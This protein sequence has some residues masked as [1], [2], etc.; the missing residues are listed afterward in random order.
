MICPC[1]D[2]VA[3]KR[4]EACHDSCPE[5]KEWKAPLIAQYE[6]RKIASLQQSTSDSKRR[7]LRRALLMAKKGRRP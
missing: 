1:K 6:E 7:Y 2:C 5:Y 4:H 3:P